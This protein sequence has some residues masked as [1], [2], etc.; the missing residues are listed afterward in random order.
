MRHKS[1]QGR[2]YVTW[3][4]VRQTQ[5]TSRFVR[6]WPSS[7]SKH[8][9]DDMSL[10]FQ[11]I[12]QRYILCSSSPT[13]S[14]ASCEWAPT[15]YGQKF[16]DVL[17]YIFWTFQASLR[18]I[19]VTAIVCERFFR[20]GAVLT[21]SAHNFTLGIASFIIALACSWIVRLALQGVSD[22]VYV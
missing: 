14:C 20:N 21:A 18:T 16:S 22:T 9:L 10:N 12:Q 13:L 1:L 8:Q 5:Q 6:Q 15:L 3:Q 4:C 17:T 2:F 19:S 7:D 11:H